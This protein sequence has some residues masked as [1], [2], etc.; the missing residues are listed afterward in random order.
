MLKYTLQKTQENIHIIDR[1]NFIQF[2]FKDNMKRELHQ[3]PF[4]GSQVTP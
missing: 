1:L 4:S 3:I 2:R